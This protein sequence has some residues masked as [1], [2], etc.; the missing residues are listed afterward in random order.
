MSTFNCWA[1]IAAAT[2]ATTAPVLAQA[3]GT[4]AH[5]TLVQP[6]PSPTPRFSYS[7]KIRAWNLYRQNASDAAQDG[8]DKAVNQAGFNLGIAPHVEYHLWKGLSVGSTYQYAAPLNGSCATAQSHL[9]APCEAVVPKGQTPSG[10]TL[11]FDDS[12]PSYRLNTLYEAY[13]TW[14]DPHFYL[15]AGNQVINTP[16]APDADSRIK[17]SAYQGVDATYALG[18]HWLLEGTRVVR[19][20][21]RNQSGFSRST[22]LT[23]S[24]PGAG[25]V[26]DTVYN[27]SGAP[28][29]TPGYTMGRLRYSGGSLEANAWYYGFAGIANAYWLEGKY[30]LSASGLRPYVSVQMGSERNSGQSVVGKINSQVYGILGGANVAKNVLVE[31]GYDY[32]PIR[33]DTMRLSSGYVCAPNHTISA[34]NVAES[35]PYFLPSGG[36]ANC[37]SN[38]DGTTNLYY[39]GWASPYGDSLAADPLFT[40]SLTQGM[41]DRRSPGQSY[42]TRVTY[43]STNRKLV[44]STTFAGYDYGNPGGAQKTHEADAD[45]LYYFSKPAAPGQTYKGFTIHYRYGARFQSGSAFPLPNGYG[46]PPLFKYDRYQ[47]EYDF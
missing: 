29:Q 36:T 45:V 17:P 39:G 21:F 38:T 4:P 44:A 31:V 19:F 42:L 15:K 1:V 11:D 16:W 28:I 12:L 35:L 13:V 18:S 46:G 47:L 33:T 41:V 34:G 37:T 24:P 3:T 10:S 23:S 25:G 27:P 5:D 26:P 22:L 8:A 30:T 40:T 32:I 14:A 7:V 20:E 43:T 6:A 2:L 9:A